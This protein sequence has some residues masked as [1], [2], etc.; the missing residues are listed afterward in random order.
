MNPII[1]PSF[2]FIVHLTLVGYQPSIDT[3]QLLSLTK[4]KNL[5]VLE[6]IQPPPS[7]TGADLDFPKISDA[8]IRQWSEEPDPFPVLRVLKIWGDYFTTPNSLQYLSKFPALAVYDVAGKERDWAR[9][10]QPPGWT[11]QGR[12]WRRGRN[13]FE[14]LF[15]CLSFLGADKVY[16]ANWQRDAG[17]LVRWN[18]IEWELSLP[19]RDRKTS[20]VDRDKVPFF[21]S[22]PASNLLFPPELEEEK[23]KNKRKFVMLFETYKK[24]IHGL[25]ANTGLQSWGYFLYCHI[26]HLWSDK[27]LAAQGIQFADKAFL[28]NDGRTGFVVPPRPYVTLQL[29]TCCEKAPFKGIGARTCCSGGTERRFEAHQTFFRAEYNPTANATPSAPAAQEASGDS[30]TSNKKKRPREPTTPSPKRM[31]KKPKSYPIREVMGRESTDPDKM[32]MD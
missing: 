24:H 2:D 27:D 16:H 30:S 6:I 15:K 10:P 1:S 26:G 19:L 4:L 28:T 32:E 12:T 21:T 22:V 20:I 13:I 18:S 14:T 11:A 23:N 8:I 9:V 7:S 31:R 17:I 3:P 25:E 5:G 29:G